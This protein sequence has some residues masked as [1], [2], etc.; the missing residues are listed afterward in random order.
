M[1]IRTTLI[2]NRTGEASIEEWELPLFGPDT[3]AR[4]FKERSIELNGRAHTH[5]VHCAHWDWYLPDLK[6]ATVVIKEYRGGILDV[7]CA[8]FAEVLLEVKKGGE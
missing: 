4:A 6:A 8:G 3:F 7:V 5:T 1:K 2:D